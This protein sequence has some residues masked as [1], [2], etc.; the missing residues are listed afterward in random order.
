MAGSADAGVLRCSNEDVNVVS[1]GMPRSSSSAV[2]RSSEQDDVE[3]SSASSKLLQQDKSAPSSVEADSKASLWSRLVS[4]TWAW[5]ALAMAL[6]IACLIAIA[7]VLR[8]HEGK[9]T[10]PMPYGVTLNAIIS[11]LATATKT[12]LL[13]AVGGAVGQV[14]WDWFRKRRSLFDLQSFDDV[15][16]GP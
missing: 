10:H 1:S 13:C 15:S 6:S 5:E 12:S 14:K 3:V 2:A 4:N 11:T 7:V 8:S 9:P 16:R